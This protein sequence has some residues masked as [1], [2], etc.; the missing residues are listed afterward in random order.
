MKWIMMRLVWAVY[1][2]HIQSNHLTFCTPQYYGT[3]SFRSTSG[4]TCA[5]SS[6]QLDPSL[7]PTLIWMATWHRN[8]FC[9]RKWNSW[10]KTWLSTRIICPQ[11]VGAERA[12]QLHP[13]ILLTSNDSLC[14]TNVITDTF[15]HCSMYSVPVMPWPMN[16]VVVLT[17]LSPSLFII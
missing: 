5:T 14:Y 17:S 8:K 4:I 7:T 16:V 15:T 13:R 12:P 1:G 2:F 10:R 9:P 6:T 11:Q 3:N